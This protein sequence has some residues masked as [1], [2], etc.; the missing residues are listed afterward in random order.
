MRSSNRLATPTLINWPRPH[1]T[2]II[3]TALSLQTKT[4]DTIHYSLYIHCVCLWSNCSIALSRTIAQASCGGASLYTGRLYKMWRATPHLFYART[5]IVSCHKLLAFVMIMYIIR[6]V[7]T[8]PGPI[9]A[10]PLVDIYKRVEV[11]MWTCN[12]SFFHWLVIKT[13]SGSLDSLLTLMIMLGCNCTI[14][15]LP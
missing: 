6:K 14:Y 11:G 2:T 1:S 5:R 12:I 3:S 4:H 10:I 15:P 8:R 7:C 13:C 9:C